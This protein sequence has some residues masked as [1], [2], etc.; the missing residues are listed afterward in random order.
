MPAFGTLGSMAYT[1]AATT[2]NASFTATAGRDLQVAIRHYVDEAPSSV[3]WNT[4]EAMTLL[5]ARQGSGSL[6]QS[7]YYL[8]NPTAGTHNITITMP[9]SQ[10][11]LWAVPFDYS[12]PNTGTYQSGGTGSS[13]LS[14]SPSLTVS[15]A[16]GDLV[17]ATYIDNGGGGTPT[18]SPGTDTNV[19]GTRLTGANGESF[20]LMDEVGAASV[21]I[22]GTT[23]VTN[24]WRM[25]GA[26]FLAAAASASKI[27]SIPM[28]LPN[29]GLPSI[30]LSIVGV[31]R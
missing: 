26:S 9:S 13:G 29:I 8:I 1:E 18:L 5:V 2:L 14:G 6:W 27:N 3:V 19:R 20:Y 30:G 12:S 17:I 23:G 10:T 15:S 24:N 31:R 28:G 7:R 4:S 21:V 22:G 11:Y 16:T 25:V